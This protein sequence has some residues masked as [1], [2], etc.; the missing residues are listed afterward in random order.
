MTGSGVT[1]SGDTWQGMGRVLRE[2]MEVTGTM[3]DI[4]LNS[5]SSHA[6]SSFNCP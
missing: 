3:T 5:P 4:R 6:Y 1:G 2:K